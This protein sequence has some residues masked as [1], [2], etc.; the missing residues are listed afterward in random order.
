MMN[1]PRYHKSSIQ[2]HIVYTQKQHLLFYTINNIKI[3]TIKHM[4]K[5][6]NTKSYIFNIK[7]INPLLK[8]NSYHS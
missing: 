5:N 7:L 4:L 2:W 1:L 8:H 3:I 6:I